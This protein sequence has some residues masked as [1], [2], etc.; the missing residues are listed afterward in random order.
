M[1]VKKQLPD[2]NTLNLHSAT[3]PVLSEAMY[4]MLCSPAG[5]LSPACFPNCVM[6]GMTPELSVAVGGVH[7]TDTDVVPR[8]AVLTIFEGQFEKV[9]PETSWNKTNKKYINKHVH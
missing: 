8:S 3:F 7:V 1:P 2:T 4:R 9:G 5:N 6:L